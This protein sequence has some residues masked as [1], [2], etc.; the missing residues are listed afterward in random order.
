M[1]PFFG[2]VLVL[3]VLGG[4]LPG[5]RFL[6]VKGH[7]G[8][9]TARKL[10]HVGMGCVCLTFPRLFDANWPVWLLAG[11]A[12]FSLLLLR[13]IKGL[14]R[15]LGSVLH[16]VDRNSLGELYF[17]LGVATVFTLAGDH[18]LLF[19][20][21]VALLTFADAAG[22]L[23]GRRLGRHPFATLEGTKSVEGSLAV[24]LAGMACASLPLLIYGYDP[25]RALLI[26]AALGLFALLVEAIS[27]RGLDNIFL[28][29]A[30][31]AQ[32]SAFL[33]ASSGELVLRLSVLA[34]VTLL[35]LLWRRGHVV[36]DSARLGGA[37]AMYYFW[38]VGGWTWLVAPVVILVS[39]VRLMPT[40]PGGP[41]QH[42]LIAVICVASAGLIW[43]VA[44]AVVPDPRWHGLFT[45]GL[46]TQQAIIALVRFS[47]GRPHWPRAAWCAIAVGQAA[48]LH[49]LTFWWVDRR[50][51]VSV[52]GLALG[53]AMVAFATAAFALWE[54][55]LRLPDDVNARW[56]KQGLTALAAAGLAG[57]F[58][59]L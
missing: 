4:F 33:H 57:S 26:G 17:P 8:P 28:P 31:F 24:G 42:N 35:A 1:T 54:R 55:S 16:D 41:P 51:T 6:Q 37:L 34:G 20:V 48:G 12:A 22:A 59:F 19:L 58:W 15:G 44:H 46:A 52:E 38:V 49:G 7:V 23:V 30:I 13:T 27:W 2:I 56:W 21:P 3:V 47:Q 14:R 25:L 11:L 40:I 36:D 18:D 50:A 29:L 45:L 5:V 9:E 53:V 32:L 43:S 10:V 39:Y